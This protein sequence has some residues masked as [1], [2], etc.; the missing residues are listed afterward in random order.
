[1][2]LGPRSV[3]KKVVAVVA[4]ALIATGC[5]AQESRSAL[6]SDS[7]QVEASS[8][9]AEPSTEPVEPALSPSPL[10]SAG[11]QPGDAASA[12]GAGADTGSSSPSE[13]FASASPSDTSTGLDDAEVNSM[14]PGPQVGFIFDIIGLGFDLIG[15]AFDIADASSGQGQAQATDLTEVYQRLDRIE[16][17]LEQSRVDN[18]ARF[19]ELQNEL[20]RQGMEASIR[21]F[22]DIE[23]NGDEAMR[24]WL[25]IHQCRINRARSQPTCPDLGGVQRPV[26]DSILRARSTLIDVVDNRWSNL[27]IPTLAGAYN[28]RGAGRGLVEGAWN[29]LRTKQN[30]AAQVPASSPI[31]SGQKMPVITPE[32]SSGMNAIIEY[33][34]VL[35]ARYAFLRQVAVLE[36]DPTQ[37]GC[38]WYEHI[39]EFFKVNVC[40]RRLME[41]IGQEADRWIA[42]TGSGSVLQAAATYKMPIVPQGAI[43]VAGIGEGIWDGSSPKNWILPTDTLRRI[44]FSDPVDQPARPDTGYSIEPM[45]AVGNGGRDDLMAMAGALEKYAGDDSHNGRARVMTAFPNAFAIYASPRGSAARYQAERL[46]AGGCPARMDMGSAWMFSSASCTPGLSANWVTVQVSEPGTDYPMFGW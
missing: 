9:E 21:Q 12:P 28:S 14:D 25:V 5:S 39:A 30:N 8:L 10:A 4:V 41:Q 11:S 34:A 46:P 17:S 26:E 27:D 23:N 20:N 36:K 15:L 37:N 38:Q 3:G 32:L 16:S 13:D 7:E 45:R 40:Q 35:I 2:R 19:S 18:Q 6:G 33:Y 1:M 22:I 29:F 43:A 42:G 44:M 24:A 31:R